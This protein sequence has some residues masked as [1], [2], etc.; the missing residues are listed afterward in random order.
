ML[1]VPKAREAM[2]APKVLTL[3]MLLMLLLK[4]A[5]KM[6]VKSHGRPLIWPD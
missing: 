3:L 2:K 1:K 4:V 6:E 5:R